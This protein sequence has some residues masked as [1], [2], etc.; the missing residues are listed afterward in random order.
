[1]KIF[2]VIV[3]CVVLCGAYSC[4]V[5]SSFGNK[6]TTINSACDN[7]ESNNKFYRGFG[8]IEVRPDNSG[9][10]VDALSEAKD[11]ARQEIIKEIELD[12]QVVAKRINER[13]PDGRTSSQYKQALHVQ[14][15][16]RLQNT[17][18]K[19]NESK[20]VKRSRKSQEML[21]AS[22]CIEM[23][24]KDFNDDIYKANYEM[25]SSSGI[26]KNTYDIWLSSRVVKKK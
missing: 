22:V 3:L 23:S 9:A 21:V 17:E 14:A 1:M 5:Y 26:D 24:K 8:E 4:S 6:T 25:F 16:N 12:G 15:Y 18:L 10:R 20:L 7:C 2:K 19:C 13:E 11:I